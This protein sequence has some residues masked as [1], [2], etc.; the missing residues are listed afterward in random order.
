MGSQALAID[1]NQMSY[2]TVGE[3]LGVDQSKWA[4]GVLADDGCIYAAPCNAKS[5]LRI[6]PVTQ[7]C[8]T[9][10]CLGAGGL[11]Y[12]GAILGLDSKVYCIPSGNARS[13]LCVDTQRL[14]IALSQPIKCEDLPEQSKWRGGIVASTGHIFC[15]PSNAAEVL[16]IA[17][18]IYIDM[19]VAYVNKNEPCTVALRDNQI[20]PVANLNGLTGEGA[21]EDDD[22]RYL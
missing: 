20:A 17:P 4:G 1:P 7:T 6:D 21:G 16:V 13:V 15:V 8:T 14:K 18:E 22:D 10:G 11:K 19:K 5:V 2:A 3:N 12:D 9:F